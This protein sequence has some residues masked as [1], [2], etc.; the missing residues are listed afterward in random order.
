MANIVIVATPMVER[1]LLDQAHAAGLEGESADVAAQVWWLC[2]TRWLLSWWGWRLATD[3]EMCMFRAWARSLGDNA[4]DGW[5]VDPG[6]KLE[7]LAK[8]DA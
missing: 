5:D 3:E 6:T 4:P 2:G 1:V 8:G 7:D